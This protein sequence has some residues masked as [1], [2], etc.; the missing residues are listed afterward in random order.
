MQQFFAVFLL[1]CSFYP[2]NKQ[3]V[4]EVVELFLDFEVTEHELGKFKVH[5][6]DVVYVLY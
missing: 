3:V 2:I 4:K 5:A 1:I 6:E